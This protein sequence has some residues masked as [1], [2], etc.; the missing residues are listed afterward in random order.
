MHQSFCSPS[1]L[2]CMWIARS[3]ILWEPEAHSGL[4]ESHGVGKSCRERVESMCKADKTAGWGEGGRG[5]QAR[6]EWLTKQLV[7]LV[8]DRLVQTGGVQVVVVVVVGAE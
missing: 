4:S 6:S 5:G 7:P 1:P 2:W 8:L 3:H